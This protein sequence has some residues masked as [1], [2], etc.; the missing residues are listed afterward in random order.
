VSSITQAMT[1]IRQINAAQLQQES[2][3][4]R[5]LTQRDITTDLC[6][7]IWHFVKR[8]KLTTKGHLKEADIK[9]FKMLPWYLRQELRS[10][11]YEPKIRAHPLFNL[12]KHCEKDT[13]LEICGE[14]IVEQHVTEGNEVVQRGAIVDDLV[15]VSSGHLE[16]ATDPPWNRDVVQSTPGSWLCEVGLWGNDARLHGMLSAGDRGCDVVLVKG[17]EFRSVLKRS[18]RALPLAA[19]YAV[20]FVER[21]KAAS[22]DETWED[23]LFNG[24]AL[25]EDILFET[26][27]EDYPYYLA[28]LTKLG[29]SAVFQ[30][31][32]TSRAGRDQSWSTRSPSEKAP[33]KPSIFLA[34]VSN[35]RKSAA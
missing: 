20:A 31:M 4:R 34:A 14:A 10:Q 2:L 9:V 6:G 25:I 29:Y 28:V 1:T 27:C 16:Y 26:V 3:I 18:P 24:M 11:A 19:S 13:M 33:E 7:R 32:A 30:Q 23:I 12:F 35:L 15:F 5:F 21:F 8:H 17:I 22:F